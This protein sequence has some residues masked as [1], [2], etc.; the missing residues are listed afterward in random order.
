MTEKKTWTIVRIILALVV[1]V[2]TLYAFVIKQECDV[3]AV[4]LWCRTHP[5]GLGDWIGSAL[6][7]G[8]ALF[9]SGLLPIQLWNEEN[10][11]RWN[12]ILFGI[13]FVGLVLIW[14]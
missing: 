10:S 12:F 4:Y 3:D 1:L 14:V 2:F 7:Y 6:F 8:G 13:M 5:M 9:M 11:T